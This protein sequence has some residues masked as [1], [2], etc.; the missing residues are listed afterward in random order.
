MWEREGEQGREVAGVVTLREGGEEEEEGE[1]RREEVGP[2]AGLVG[3]LGLGA[4]GEWE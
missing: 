2:E 1:Q 3:E 4:L